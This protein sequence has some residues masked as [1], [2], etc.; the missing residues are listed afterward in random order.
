MDIEVPK[1]VDIVIAKINSWLAHFIELLP[2]LVVAIIVVILFY[3]F[4][5]TARSLSK[6]LF[7]QFSDKPVLHGLL[8]RFI[9]LTIVSIGLIIA[10]NVLQLEKTVTSLLAGAGV[11]GLALGFAFQDISANFISGALLAIRRPIIVGDVVESNGYMGTVEKID[12]RETIIQTFQGLHVIIPNK[13]VLQSAITNYTKTHERRIDLQVG[14]SYGDDLKK[15]KQVAEEAVAALPELLPNHDVNLFFT[16]FGD[17]SINF[18]ITFW[19]HY[20]NEPGF[21][22]AR[23]EA[24][25]QIKERFDENGITIPFPIRTL[26]FGIKGGEKLSEM[27]LSLDGK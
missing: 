18:M 4:A 16:E 6:K 2:N 11:I 13:D 7:R 27:G 5:R 20:P 26:D 25:I 21:L 14:V 12:L 1:A 3:L 10:L 17:S 8:A 15:V 22:K 9:F 24:I 19:I 23:S